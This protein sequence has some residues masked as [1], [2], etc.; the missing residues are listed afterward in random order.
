M[1]PR[2]NEEML[3][4][5][6]NSNR[7]GSRNLNAREDRVRRMRNILES[8]TNLGNL[9]S[10][11]GIMNPIDFFAIHSEHNEN[12]HSVFEGVR[13]VLLHGT[14][15]PSPESGTINDVYNFNYNRQ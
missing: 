13:N 3:F 9:P 11:H 2:P 6:V 12:E 1:Q 10:I 14:N 8:E 15:P 7:R 4:Q 5:P